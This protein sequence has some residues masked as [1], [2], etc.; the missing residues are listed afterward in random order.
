VLE[1]AGC[2]L[3]L[4]GPRPRVL[5]RSVKDGGALHRTAEGRLFF[6]DLGE[7]LLRLD[8]WV[9]TAWPG[10]R[11][12][13]FTEFSVEHLGHTL[14][15]E[16][17]LGVLVLPGLEAVDGLLADEGVEGLVGEEGGVLAVYNYAHTIN[18]VINPAWGRPSAS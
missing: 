3:Q 15:V 5:N 12:F 4:V 10:L 9:V 17:G 13:D 16:F 1:G 7:G 2:P 18:K 14:V 6:F 11:V 8:E